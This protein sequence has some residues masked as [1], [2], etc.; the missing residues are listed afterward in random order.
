MVPDDQRSLWNSYAIREVAPLIISGA[1]SM[2]EGIESAARSADRLAQRLG[3]TKSDIVLDIGPGLGFHGVHLAQLCKLWIGVDISS[4]LL[5][6][7]VLRRSS[8][9]SLARVVTSGYDLAC[10]S[11]CSVSVV[12]SIAV[13]LHLEEWQRYNYIRESFRVLRPGAKFTLNP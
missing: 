1:K 6:S 12:Y 11:D 8:L 5:Q 2:E 4:E 13:F 10:F 9:A 3:I 7:D